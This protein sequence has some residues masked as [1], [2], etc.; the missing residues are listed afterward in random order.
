MSLLL[1]AGERYPT[2]AGP[3]AAIVLEEGCNPKQ[4]SKIAM[5][6]SPGLLV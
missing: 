4:V 2:S 6:V 5:G 3:K 1:D